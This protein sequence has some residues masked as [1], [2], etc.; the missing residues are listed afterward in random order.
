MQPTDITDACLNPSNGKRVALLWDESFLWGLMACEGLLQADFSFDV[1]RFSEICPDRLAG[2]TLLIVPGGWA[3]RKYR[4]LG[5]KKEVIRRFVAQGGGY[6]GFCGGA[7]LAL[8]VPE[9][10][11]LIPVR[12]KQAGERLPN[13]SGSILIRCGEGQH[14]F[15]T[16]INGP[17]PMCVWWPSQFEVVDWK[18]VEVLGRYAEP[19]ED[20]FVAD[21]NVWEV[22]GA[23]TPWKD[24]E[25]R[26]GINLDP[27]RLEGEPALLEGRYGL[28]TVVASYVHLET[29]ENMWGLLGL[30]NLLHYLLSQLRDKSTRTKGL[31]EICQSVPVE[32]G[33]ASRIRIIASDL[34]AGIRFL[35]EKGGLLGYWKRRNDR[36]LIWKRGVNGFAFNTI[37]KMIQ[38]IHRI[39]GCQSIRLAA[40]L[41]PDRF[42]RVMEDAARDA[43]ELFGR[44][45]VEMESLSQA[46]IGSLESR[47]ENGGLLSPLSGSGAWD[48]PLGTLLAKLDW[49]VY[50]L[51]GARWGLSSCRGSSA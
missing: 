39:G 45:V 36:F 16:G 12:R 27:R 17:R 26:Y 32:D 38:E 23:G 34:D 5:E 20:F 50:E 13:F 46:G 37:E 18:A 6:L 49:I 25:A 40:D 47:H 11:G 1:I 30:S 2:Y 22:E 15:W 31:S 7:G 42:L 9:G 41:S 21:L 33:H 3:S 4:G 44:T 19:C 10:L 24:L 48:G 43:Q 51:L 28:G 29:P 14:P 35:V 8:D